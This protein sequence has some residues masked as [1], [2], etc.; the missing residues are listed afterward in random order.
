MKKVITLLAAVLLHGTIASGADLQSPQSVQ[1]RLAVSP[2]RPLQGLPVD[3][4]DVVLQSYTFDAAGSP[5]PQGWIA[6]DTSADYRPFTHVDDHL[7]P[8]SGTKSLWCGAVAD[9]DNPAT[10]DWISSGYGND[11][12]QSWVSRAFTTTTSAMTVMSC[13]FQWQLNVTSS[14]GES[15]RLEYRT[16]GGSWILS[17][18]YTNGSGTEDLNIGASLPVGTTIEYRFV[19]TSDGTVSNADGSMAA[20]GAFLLDDL[21]VQNGSTN[22]LS[23][24]DFEAE[25]IGATATLSGDWHAE[26]EAGFGTYASL[27][28]GN[29]VRQDDPATYNSSHFWGF[30]AGSPDIYN[31]IEPSTAVPTRDP[32]TGLSI[33]NEIRSPWTPVDVAAGV[34]SVRV[35]YDVYLD[36]PF[37][38]GGLTPYHRV[39]LLCRDASG[40]FI[41][42]QVTD[43]HYGTPAAWIPL[44]H[45][46]F[47]PA[48]TAAVQTV[49]QVEELAEY[50][51]HRHAPL[52]DNV[53][54]SQNTAYTVNAHITTL[55]GS[56][57]WAIN[58]ANANPGP[59]V[60]EFDLM[61]G[62]TVY[63]NTVLPSI[64]ETVHILGATAPGSQPNTLTGANDAVI[65]TRLVN[66]YSESVPALDI[67][68]D[69]C[70]IEGLAFEGFNSGNIRIAGNNNTVRGCW[71]GSD[72]DG[73]YQPP[74]SG[75]QIEL[76][77]AGTG[78]PAFTDNTIG[79]P[80]PAD[81]NVIG[82][83][84][85]SAIKARKQQSLTVR[86]NLIG[87]QPDGQTAR[88]AK[89]GVE[90]V[91][92]DD[93]LIRDNVISGN[94]RDTY[95]SG[96]K[97][98]NGG[99]HTIRGNIIGLSGSQAL[100]VPNEYAGIDYQGSRGTTLIG[101]PD[102]GTGNVIAG[103]G[104]PG[105]IVS[106]DGTV[107]IFSNSIG[108]NAA[109]YATHLGNGGQGVHMTYAT[110][111]DVTVGELYG[112]NVIAHNGGAGIEVGEF[113]NDLF[114]IQSNSI[115]N[116]DGPEID[117]S[118]WTGTPVPVPV[119]T[120]ASL[121]GLT[122]TTVG[123]LDGDPNTEY[124]VDLFANR[125]CGDPGDPEARE[126]LGS[127]F[128]TTDA[129]GRGVF[130]RLVDVSVYP[131]DT[132]T[133][134]AS[135]WL[136]H[137]S[138]AISDCLQSI[139][140]PQGSN[141]AVSLPVENEE[142]LPITATFDLVTI[143]G[144]TSVIYAD[145]CPGAPP[146]YQVLGYYEVSTTAA[147]DQNVTF[148]FDYDPAGIPGGSEVG[149]MVLQ[150]IDDPG[151]P[152]L[153]VTGGHDPA[154]DTICG[155]VSSLDVYP[156]QCLAI[157]AP[158]G[159]SW[160]PDAVA[161]FRLL[162][163]Y[164]NPFNP[165]TTV[166]F[167]LPRAADQVTV[168]VY[169]IAGRRVRRLHSGP[170]SSGRTDLVWN[171]T[172]AAGR[173][174]VSGVYLVQVVNG[175]EK[176]SQRLMLLK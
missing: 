24:E 36:S 22:V 170:A 133:A 93:A 48:G 57:Y 120:Q 26:S 162:P 87:L 121:D 25:P 115:H 29:L 149:M 152:F 17:R 171:G 135:R 85:D 77:D 32:V 1:P 114:L 69:G 160:T 66:N 46:F 168:D 76:S 138:S 42:S 49:F 99:G 47:L 111:L 50:P 142:T 10:H 13:E 140:T 54:V 90:L 176:L 28:E 60:I 71:L 39:K 30:F 68:A 103:N 169:D 94:T 146:G 78:N 75:P 126:Y 105:I 158:L 148:C 72:P 37:G 167:E 164:P 163:N 144:N 119:L 82:N 175:Q 141:V 52:I 159:V 161:A 97:I 118:L 155:V 136:G 53:V 106:G 70:V 156:G 92:C 98:G 143:A 67:Q 74:I 55:P 107:G 124:L 21:L 117:F 166:S 43:F 23:F 3:K 19:F 59:D 16:N 31:C 73:A 58:Q 40:Q 131:N 83:S 33:S 172:D 12:D 35:D 38:A 5:D 122:L 150:G 165:S 7:P 20:P 65:M 51:C 95:S 173:S 102:P 45:R 100:A 109:G 104:G 134:I 63:L 137:G 151:D 9:T 88:G 113:M 174:V 8:L 129:L 34:K 44:S 15:I 147:F 145:D 96:I 27:F 130:Y 123:Y 2:P 18:N 127:A 110:S 6:V 154:N 101:R 108:T 61:T 116:N 62:S 139:N 81:H 86:G 153:D 41:S 125:D 128:A 11:W 84:W 91:N 4:A 64:T 89:H 112:G 157:V 14:N 79:G 132:V 56:L 80:D